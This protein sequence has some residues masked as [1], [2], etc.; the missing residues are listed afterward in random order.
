MRGDIGAKLKIRILNEEGQKVITLG[1][2]RTDPENKV[3]GSL[4]KYYEDLISIP[5][6]GQNG[7]IGNKVDIMSDP[8]KY[9]DVDHD[10]YKSLANSY[11]LIKQCYEERSGYAVGYI[12]GDEFN[13]AASFFRNQSN[14]MH[15]S[16]SRRNQI[17]ANAISNAKRIIFPASA[18]R[19]ERSDYCSLQY[20]TFMNTDF[21]SNIIESG[22][23]SRN[24]GT[25]NTID[26]IVY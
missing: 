16:T 15:L 25:I 2:K 24:D 6:A 21:W 23:Q 8:Q 19:K 14:Q 10:N 3:I 22:R 18:W 4:I 26:T 1:R 13:R 9:K 12:T 5:I 20:S 7:M 11:F 17:D